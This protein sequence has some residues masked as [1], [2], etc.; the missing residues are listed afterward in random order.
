MRKNQKAKNRGFTLIEL[1]IG[2][3]IM[4]ILIGIVTMG[5]TNM[6]TS[7]RLGAGVRDVVGLL[8]YSRTRAFT[9]MRAYRM[10]FCVAGR[11]CRIIE[12]TAGDYN[13][14]NISLRG[15]FFVEQCPSSRLNGQTCGDVGQRHEVKFY[16]IARAFKDVEISSLMHRG[17]T[18]TRSTLILYFRTDGSIS[19][20]TQTAGNPPI[21]TDGTY[22]ICLRSSQQMAGSQATFIPKRIEISFDGRIRT[23]TDIQRLC[24]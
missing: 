18:A 16:N 24:H 14:P 5:S 19:S 11:A 15:L 21:C 6:T 20:C 12:K 23:F 1:M 13:I 2:L 7:A 8:T 10:Q 4:G 22:Y 9:T 17:E 3:V